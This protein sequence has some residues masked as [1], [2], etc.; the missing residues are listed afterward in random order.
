M[1]DVE[2]IKSA[3]EVDAIPPIDPVC[4]ART[5][6]GIQGKP[7]GFAVCQTNEDYRRHCKFAHDFGHGIATCHHPLHEEIVAR[8]VAA[9]TP[10]KD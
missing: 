6:A 3:K 1:E 2:E 8:T 10:A 7:L 9:D 5:L 4:R